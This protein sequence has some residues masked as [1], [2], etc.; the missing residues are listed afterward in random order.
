MGN[1]KIISDI[2]RRMLVD[3]RDDISDILNNY[4]L[5]PAET[6]IVDGYVEE[7]SA[8]IVEHNSGNALNE[9]WD[10]YG[11]LAKKAKNY[12]TA[13]GTLI[14]AIFGYVLEKSPQGVGFGALVGGLGARSIE[15]L[16]EP[17]GRVMGVPS[18][19]GVPGTLSYLGKLNENYRTQLSELNS[20][21]Q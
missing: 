4:T 18:R 12:A 6:I 14:G 13:A 16:F 3:K 20:S 8:F 11:P 9:Y 7:M 17:T 15:T 10:E 19:A 21:T 1:S 5:D 2:C